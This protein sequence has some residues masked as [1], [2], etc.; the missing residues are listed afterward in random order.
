MEF[1]KIEPEDEKP[2]LI[3]AMMAG[4][5]QYISGHT[6]IPISPEDEGGESLDDFE[7][8]TIAFLVLCQ[9]MYD[10]RTMMPDSKYA[11]SA[12]KTVDSILGLHA[13]NL[14]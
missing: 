10:N 7:D 1:I 12:N 9:D 4:A 5:R 14:L 8:L 11:N 3:E 13:R 6:G 2:E